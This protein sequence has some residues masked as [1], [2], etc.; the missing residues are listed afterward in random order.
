MRERPFHPTRRSAVA[1]LAVTAFCG[2]A[3]W[4]DDSCEQSGVTLISGN[5]GELDAL[6]ED[7]RTMI[8]R[9]EDW[10]DYGSV[11]EAGREGEWDYTWAGATPVGIVRKDSTFFFYY[12]ASDGY[13][14]HDGGPRHRAIGVATSR[15]GI[16][17]TKY[18]GNPI[19]THTPLQGEEEGANSAAI[20]LSEDGEFTM[21][22]G[23]ATGAGAEINADA[24]LAVSDDGLH[25]TD[26]TKV[27][28][29]TDRCVFGHGDEIFPQAAF[30]SGGNWHVFYV[31]NGSRE[32]GKLSIAVGPQ[33]T[34]LPV[35][36]E[37]LGLQPLPISVWGNVSQLSPD[38]AA[39]FVQ[40]GIWPNT[41]AE[42]RAFSPRS[43][44][45]LS[46]P[47]ARYDIPDLKRGTAYLDTDRRTWFMY[48]NDF[49][50]FWDLKLAPAGE[51][52][53]TPPT[54]P[55]TLTARPL[56]HDRVELSWE[57]ATD[58]ETGVVMYRV[59]RNGV[60]VG[61][62]KQTS[63]VDRELDELTPYAYEVTAIN[64][65]G[66]EGAAAVRDVSTLG[67]SAPPEVASAVA[68]GSTT[69]TVRFTEPV[70]RKSAKTISNYLLSTGGDPVAM[71]QAKLAVDGRAVSLVTP[72]HEQGREYRLVVRN[73]RDRARQRN[74]MTEPATVVYAYSP[75]GGLVGYWPF[76]E[77]AAAS[78]PDLSG[79]GEHATVHGA[80]LADG[81]L[82]KALRFSGASDYVTIA[83]SGSLA[84][85]TD[86][87]FTFSIWARPQSAPSRQFG[88]GIILRSASWPFHVFGVSYLPGERYQAQLFD[89]SSSE[90]SI[91][92]DSVGP[93]TW[94]HVVMAVDHDARLLHLY[95]DGDAV[96]GSPQRYTGALLDLKDAASA[97]EAGML[98]VGSAKPDRGAGAYF[99]RHLHGLVDELRI[100]DRALSHTEVRELF[101]AGG[102]ARVQGSTLSPR[103]KPA[104]DGAPSQ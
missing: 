38:V 69:V 17:F 83:D 10:V 90:T 65:H 47:I 66:F 78:T 61:T 45:M 39:V 92:T 28:D 15:D 71:S 103:S 20:A 51:P 18:D 36:S 13:R 43:P 80:A 37:V 49:D 85:L 34:S 74:S 101:E 31:P 96:A 67:D 53:E 21:Y 48:Y 25:F 76:D 70:D 104:S 1:L 30:A 99:T 50:R 75:I 89:T 93:G 59:Y 32:S 4:N 94:R 35:S 88:Y 91:A 33:T 87:S 3:V 12:V 84:N 86:K 9:N 73:V 41:V 16:H 42:V 29:H 100:Y 40:R 77:V 63:F 62:V 26:V 57:P 7:I 98:Y 6:I 19:L 52:D 60:E 2:C 44:H 68:T 81:I 27:L 8:P 82:G 54:K 46:A 97:A 79:Y 11:L 5:T 95:L 14:S 55:S 72:P 56:G 22:Y 64:L 23:A 24:R 102:R 58:L